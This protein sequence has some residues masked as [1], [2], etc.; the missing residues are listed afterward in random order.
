MK[1]DIKLS[2]KESRR[3]Y[4]MEQVL[5]GT[6]TVREAA[7]RLGLSERHVKRLK[8]GMKLYGL[9]FLAH[10][11]R[12]RK[13]KHALSDQLRYKT[14]DLIRNRYY[15]T[16]CQHMSE[17][18]AEH[19]NIHLSAKTITRLLKSE[20][21]KLRCSHK[22]PGKHRRRAR[23]SRKGMLVQIDASP[24]NWLEDRGPCLSLHG[25]I[26]DATG[27]IL[28]LCF[29]PT[30]DATGYMTVLEDVVRNF[31]VPGAVYN[32]RHTIFFSP[33]KDKLTVEEELS[34]KTINLTQVGRAL[35]ELGIDH[36]AA[37][38]PQAKGRVERMWH[39]LQTRL[40]VELR[41]L[42]VST[43]EQANTILPKIITKLNRQFAV[44]PDDPQ[45]GFR[46]APSQEVLQTIFCFKEQRKADA[47]STISY[48]GHKYQLITKDKRIVSTK[49]KQIITVLVHLDGSIS[50]LLGDKHYSL[51]EVKIPSKQNQP[52]PQHNPKA[53]DS[54]P[55]TTSSPWRR[56]YKPI[57]PRSQVELYLIEKVLA[58]AGR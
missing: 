8:G 5:S 23:K 10:K 32:D 41:I 17:L 16:S 13:P 43:I 14:L 9:A 11:N 40:P 7:G 52:A 1:G 20:G 49:P 26:D 42:A 2:L 30:E 6:L 48:R 38:S 55:K 39:T 19:D 44:E 31:G 12:G 22:T 51:T 28:S 18:L 47:G 53:A 15:G 45:T 56:P 33:N 50:A 29:R 3:V 34:G 4:V 25:A 35:S 36:I 24:H 57:P 21:I 37:H 27:E 58:R 54:K 46:T